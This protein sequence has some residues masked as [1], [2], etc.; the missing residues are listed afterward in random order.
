MPRDQGSRTGRGVKHDHRSIG[1]DIDHQIRKRACFREGWS[2][3]GES[4]A[5]LSA[6][7]DDFDGSQFSQVS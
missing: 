1:L 3:I 6:G 5:G 7:V 2:V 4:I